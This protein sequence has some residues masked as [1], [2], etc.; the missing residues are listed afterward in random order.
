M[1]S[2]HRYKQGIRRG[3]G[4]VGYNVSQQGGK[5]PGQGQRKRRTCTVLMKE[6]QENMQGEASRK[7][8]T[9]IP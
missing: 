6:R 3:R 2:G 7:H 1:E 4:K 5:C 9:K 8:R